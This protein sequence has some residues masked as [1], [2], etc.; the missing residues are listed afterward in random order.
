MS[1]ARHG[2]DHSIPPHAINYRANLA[3][4]KELGATNVIALNTVGVVSDVRQSGQ[5]AV[6]DQIIDYTWGREHTIF[7]GEDGVVEHIEFTEPFSRELRERLL[8]AAKAADIDCFDGGVYAATWG[9]GWRR[10]PKSIASSGM[11]QTMSA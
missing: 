10:Q 8:A 11:V 1:I 7:D 9:R 4:L 5:L 3:G 2:D 6:P